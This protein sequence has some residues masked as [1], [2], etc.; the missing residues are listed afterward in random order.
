[1][2]RQLHDDMIA[3]VT[4][5]GA[6]SEVFAVANGVKQGCVLTP[7]LYSLMFSAMLMDAYCDERPGIRVAYRMDVQLLNQQ[8]MRFQSR[9]STTTVHE[10][11]FAGDCAP[12]IIPEG[13]K[14][15][16]MDLFVAACDNFSLIINKEKTVVMHQPPP[17]VAYVAHQLE[18]RQTASRG[19]LTYLGNIRYGGSCTHHHCTQSQRIDNRQP[20]HRQHR[21][22]TFTRRMGL[23]GHMRTNESGSHHSC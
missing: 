4:D 17:D 13:D 9:V 11:L 16:S 14:Q 6:D 21:P 19:Q 18:R 22:R 12:K 5:N 8:W 3:Q 23:L 1:M 20:H 10:L 2:V 15:T 7:I